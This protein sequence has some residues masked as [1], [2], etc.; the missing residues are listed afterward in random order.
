[1]ARDLVG[2]DTITLKGDPLSRAMAALRVARQQVRLAVAETRS[3]RLVPVLC[4]ADDEITLRL[5]R[6]EDA[7][8]DDAADSAEAHET[9]SRRQ[10]EL[11]LQAA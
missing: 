9:L 10:A 8:D 3:S 11:P 7:L 4:D 2:F 1:M 5:C 6:I